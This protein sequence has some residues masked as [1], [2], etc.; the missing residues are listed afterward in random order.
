MQI[1]YK[2]IFNRGLVLSFLFLSL[3]SCHHEIYSHDYYE[4]KY[5]VSTIKDNSKI[6]T[7]KS[8]IEFLERDSD[9]ERQSL[10]EMQLSWGGDHNFFVI[11][12]DLNPNVVEISEWNHAIH[13]EVVTYAEF[14]NKDI[15]DFG[16]YSHD[17]LSGFSVNEYEDD[18]TTTFVK[19]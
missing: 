15:V 4:G 19:K 10:F 2:K 17:Y 16:I 6:F 3:F 14:K 1:G 11:F 9:Y 12:K 18:V 8:E 7:S 13:N 5:I